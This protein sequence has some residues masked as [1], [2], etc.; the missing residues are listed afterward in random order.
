VTEWLWSPWQSNGGGSWGWIAPPKNKSVSMFL[1][2]VTRTCRRP[3]AL[4]R[5]IR[6]LGAQDCQDFEHVIIEDKIG[7]GVAW[8]NGMM[9]KRDWSDLNG[10]YVYVLDDDNVMFHGAVM[11]M[12]NGAAS[13]HD[14]L[15]CRI[16]RL[17]SDQRSFPENEYWQRKPVHGHIDIGCVVLRKD[18]FLSSVKSFT[19]SYDGDYYY[20]SEAYRRAQ[21]VNW[22]D[23]KIMKLQRISAGRFEI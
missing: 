2:I 13:Q 14:L 22:V 8:A 12:Q 20:I 23:Y 16:N 4:A 9:A 18:L 3:K 19:E 21:S 11:A 6:S 17:R 5:C 10:D 15:I 7:R 1:S